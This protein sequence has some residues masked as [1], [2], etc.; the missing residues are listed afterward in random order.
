[1]STEEAQKNN[2]NNKK[3]TIQE[4]IKRKSCLPNNKQKRLQRR[5]HIGSGI[6]HGCGH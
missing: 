4:S 3:V 2:R 5:H 6:L 1:M